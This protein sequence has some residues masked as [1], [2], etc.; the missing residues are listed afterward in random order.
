MSE[1]QDRSEAF[2]G[3]HRGGQQPRQPEAPRF[4]QYARWLWIASAALGFLRSMVQVSDREALVSGLH[5][6]MP[7]WTQVQVDSAVNGTIMSVLVLAGAV[8]ALYWALGARLVQGK[9]WARVVVVLIGGLRTVSTVFVLLALS[10]LGAEALGR[11]SG[12]PLGPTEIGFS[13]ATAVV[14]VS[15]LVLLFLPESREH[16]R[17][18]GRGSSS[19]A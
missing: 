2:G 7:Q 11:M 12:V 4:V 5:A 19:G 3:P 8:V 9:N 15:V 17:A 1:Q 10:V 6:Q 14:D 16:F 18:R 13:L